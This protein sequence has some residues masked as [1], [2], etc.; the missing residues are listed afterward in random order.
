MPDSSIVILIGG[1]AGQGLVTIGQ[2]MSKALVRAGYEVVVSQDYQ[3]RIRGGHNTFAIRTG[4]DALHGPCEKVDILVALDAETVA[5][6]KHQLTPGGIVLTGEI[7]ALTGE[8]EGLNILRVPF[9]KISPKAAHENVVA[10]GVLAQALCKDLGL[11]EELL[12]QTFAKKGEAVIAE[13]LAVLRAAHD[14]M[15]T[16]SHGFACMPPAPENPGERMMLNGNEAIALGALAAGCNFCSF[17]PMTPGSSVALTLAAKAKAMGTVVEQAEDEIAAANMA[18]GAVCAGARAIVP[19]SGGGFAL[20]VEAVS[21]AGM[22]ETPVVFVV[23]MRPG[24]ATGLPTRTEQG[25]L[26]LVLYA[27]HGEFPRAVFAPG[28]V[29]EC[30]YLTHRAFEMAE[31]Y[32]SPV[33]LLTDQYLAD[34]FQNAEPFDLSELPEIPG[35]LLEPENPGQYKRFAHT[36]D[37]VSPRAIPGFS[38]ALVVS[39]SDEHTEDGKLTEDLDV[40]VRMVTKRLDKGLGLAEEAIAPGYIGEENADVLLACWGSTLGAALEA[41][42]RLEES[43]TRAAVLHFPQVWPLN[44][45][46]FLPQLE[47]AKRAVC[48]EGNATGQLARLI[49]QE[50]GF[51]FKDLVLRYDGLPITAAYILRGLESIL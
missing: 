11:L 4:V 23:A 39:D 27:G 48:V 45:D 50:T 3:S 32:Q 41:R 16:Q 21:L 8:T 26:N 1:E 17:Y 36:E 51:R 2:L 38:T 6:H 25:D 7:F 9:K 40:R 13:N 46:Q 44:E 20:M 47:G 43:G 14:W 19:T 24:P 10:L 35:P 33:F 12:R 49:R 31:K 34:S 5:L 30:F 15:G 37:G 42:E 22:L 29:E 18:V 28:S